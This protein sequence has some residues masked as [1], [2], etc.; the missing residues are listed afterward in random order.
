MVNINIQE[1]NFWK[2]YTCNNTTI[3]LKGCLYSHSIL[4]I[5]NILSILK[6][7]DI[8]VFIASLDGNFALTVQKHEYSFISVDKIRSTPLFFIK[9]EGDFFIDSSPARLVD[10]IGFN[11]EINDNSITEIAMSG[12][13]IGNKTIYKNLYSLKAGELVIFDN[14]FTYIQYYKYFG[15]IEYKNY[16][17]YINELSEVTLSIFRK[18]LK[19]IGSRQIIV[20]LSAGNDSRLVASVLKK[21]GANNV[22]CYSYGTTG[23]FEATISRMIANKLGFEWIFVPLTHKS[24]KEYYASQDYQNYL[25]FSQT[26]CSI[27]YI[28]GL[29]TIKYLKELNWISNDAIFINGNTGDFISGSH[30]NPL[31]K[32]LNNNLNKKERKEN[33][34]N[35]LINKHFSLWGN[36][37]TKKNIKQ[38]KATLWREIVLACGDLHNSEKDHLFYEYSEFIDR[39]TKYVN[40]AEFCYEFYGHEWR[41]PL[42]DDEYIYFWKKVPAEYK[43]EQKLYIDMLKKKNFGN[44]W[45]DDIPVNQKTIVPKWIIPLRFLAKSL[46]GLFGANGKNKWRQFEINFFYYWMDV[47]HMMDT[48]SY[49]K[50]II[51]ILKKPR[52]HASWQSENYLRGIR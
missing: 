17:N 38:I 1:C 50:V 39:Q 9:I 7:E 11:K 35:N 47:S 36:I 32:I 21:L 26:F 29:S 24:E 31:K 45:G 48:V 19:K 37:K 46:F 51:S 18:M 13:T 10:K 6:I 15:K 8:E 25:E 49:F 2:K 20:P 43:V 14:N 42:W 16:C 28:Q 40:T 52:N 27:P 30:I 22:K 33:I 5:L 23:N 12:Y 34:L 44:V 41:M 3:Y 4:S